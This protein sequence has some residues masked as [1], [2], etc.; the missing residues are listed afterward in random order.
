MQVEIFKTNVQE[1][2]E[3]AIIQTMLLEHFLD[4]T[5]NFDLNDCDKI[6][7]VKAIAIDNVRI[8]TLVSQRG[9]Y[10]EHIKE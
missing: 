8:S 5:V 2:K 7:R 10:C 9:Y 4:Y 6:L 3:A 1:A